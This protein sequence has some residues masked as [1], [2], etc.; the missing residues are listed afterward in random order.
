MELAKVLFDATADA[1]IATSPEGDVLV[2]NRGAETIFELDRTEASGRA[3]ED[4]IVP[5]EGR[6]QIRSAFERALATP[7]L[8][9]FETVRRRR[10]GLELPVSVRMEAVRDPAGGGLFLVLSARPREMNAP[11]AVFRGLLETAPDAMVI[12]GLDGRIVLINAQTESLF[13]WSRT[14][15]LGKPV[16]VLM[17]ERFREGHPEHRSYYH[18]SPRTRPMG[19]GLDLYCVRKDGSEFAAEISL[20]P[21]EVD[22]GTLVTAAIRDI[23]ERKRLEERLQETNR[24]KSEFVAN[25]S[26]ELRT[27][28]NAIIG[29]ATLLHRE[30]VGPLTAAQKE[31]LGDVLTSSRHLLQLINEVLDLARVESGRMVFNPEKFAVEPI[32]R[33]VCDGLRGLAAEK[34]IQLEYRIDPS[35]PEL[36]V[37]LAKLKQVLYNYLSNALKFTPEQGR[38]EIRIRSVDADHFAVEVEDTGIGI[39]PKDLERLFT[40][41]MQLD[42]GTGKRYPGTGLGLALTKRIV[43]A[44]GGRVSVDSTPGQGST[45]SAVLAKVIE[46]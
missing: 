38:V 6:A 40:E 43:E 31:Y 13:G 28:L 2:W 15:L 36:F 35:L 16:E 5:P 45:F 29:F 32:V 33:E 30:K 7:G 42:A 41:F 10:N 1:L 39:E 23:T 17:P 11:E 19:A 25:M 9:Q 24:L 37:D 27:P 4:L 18:S 34:R 26:H 46:A 8:I 20:S 21:I 12:V 22:D 44:Q 14:E 3:I